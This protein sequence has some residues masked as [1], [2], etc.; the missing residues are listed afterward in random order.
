LGA[1]AAAVPAQ[2]VTYFHNDISGNPVLATDQNGDVVWKA[3]YGPYG[4]EVN[5]PPAGVADHIGF[6]GHPVDRDTG[7]IYMGGRYY[8]PVLGRF[9]SPDP[10]TPDP[11]NVHS[12]NRYAYGNN[13]PYRYVDRDGHSPLD[14]AFFVWDLGKLGMAVY[15]GNPAAM[16]EA[17]I[18]VVM[19]AVGV[20]SPVPGAGQALKVARAAERGVELARG[21]EKAAGTV[22]SV[23]RAAESGAAAAKG[24]ANPKVAE[25]LKR[26]QEAHKA[27]QY[28]QGFKK[29]VTLPSGKRMDAYNQEAREVRELKP[30]N[31]RAIRQGEKQL[32]EYC[33]ECDR[34]HGPGHTGTLETY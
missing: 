7:L 22:H 30:N 13:N 11:N 14:V 18:D 26:G 12:L 1:A 6:S 9:L 8:D 27:R 23:E 25:A 10:A 17:G 34:V 3:N 33:R 21:A 15:S 28:P 20:V 5:S 4:V 29:E 2:T 24:A 31:P 19:S 16:A 32:Q